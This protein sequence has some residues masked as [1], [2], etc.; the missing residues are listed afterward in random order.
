MSKCCGKNGLMGREVT[1]KPV[2]SCQDLSEVFTS[3]L[4]AFGGAYLCL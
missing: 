3:S 1:G 4:P 2:T